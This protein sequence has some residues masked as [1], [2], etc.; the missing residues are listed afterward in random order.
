MSFQ[1][2][3]N[4]DKFYP[5]VLYTSAMRSVNSVAYNNIIVKY[6]ESTDSAFSKYTPTSAD[7][8]IMGNGKYKL[9]MGASEFTKIG[10]YEVTVTGSSFIDHN[11][12]VDTEA[13]TTNEFRN[14]VATSAALN[15][16]GTNVI[17]VSGNT[18]TIKVTT[19]KFTFS[20][21]NVN[22]YVADKHNF[23]DITVAN[24]LNGSVDNTTLEVV[25]E[26]ILA[27]CRGRVNVNGSLLTYYYGDN[28]TSAFSLSSTNYHRTRISG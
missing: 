8:V 14:R 6:F 10:T 27:Y 5:V 24:I 16:V 25:L 23:N 15:T 1:G 11:F 26:K 3:I 13:L 7:W 12:I 20:G 17:T 4:T 21:S 2:K 22:S 18:N 28:T 9:N 19:N